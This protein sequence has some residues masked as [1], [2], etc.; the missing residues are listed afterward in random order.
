MTIGNRI[1]ILKP[2]MQYRLGY[3]LGYMEADA[4]QK[5]YSA[6][7]ILDILQAIIEPP[8]G[9]AAGESK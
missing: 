4:E 9:G 6:A 3:A 1:R 2:D 7:E 8:A 5:T